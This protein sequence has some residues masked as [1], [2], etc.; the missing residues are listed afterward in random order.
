MDID[1]EKMVIRLPQKKLE[2]VRSIIQT[3]IK[4]TSLSLLDL[5]QITGYLNFLAIIVP[6]GTRF[7]KRMYNMQLYFRPHGQK[8]RRR[9]PSKARKDLNWWLKVLK[10]SPE[11]SIR[12]EARRRVRMWSDASGTKGLGAFYITGEDF[13][14]TKHY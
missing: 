8:L 13:K 6:L 12:T 10:T 2:K 1:T 14:S 3:A 11:Q 4:A 5:Q 9:I 7:L